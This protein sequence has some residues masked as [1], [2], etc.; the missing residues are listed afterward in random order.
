M[1]L[2]VG[3]GNP[4]LSM[5][6]AS[7]KLLLGA[8]MLGVLSLSELRAQEC[9]TLPA[10]P[11][12]TITS[13]HDRDQMMCQ[14]HLTLVLPIARSESCRGQRAHR[15]PVQTFEVRSRKEGKT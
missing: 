3:I 6:S 4:G 1:A 8:G 9:A 11:N 7:W 14:Q 12:A 13:T 2:A 5:T 15:M 10:V